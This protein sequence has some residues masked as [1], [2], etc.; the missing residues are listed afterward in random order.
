MEA[1]GVYCMPAWNALEAYGLQFLL[2]NPE[3]SKAVWGKKTHLK[4]GRCKTDL[5][6]DGRLEGSYVPRLAIRVFGI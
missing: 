6:Q 3:H 2:L 5:L 4:D 1:T